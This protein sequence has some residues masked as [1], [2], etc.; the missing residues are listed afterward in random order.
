MAR[1]AQ[2]PVAVAV[3]ATKFQFYDSGIMTP[4]GC[5][6]S[7][8]AVNH[9]VTIIG[10][11]RTGSA[12]YWIVRNSWGADWGEGGYLRMQMDHNTCG[13]S[14]YPYAVNTV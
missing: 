6:S 5:S 11:D 13:I 10:Y 3:D 9:A 8:N 12:P 14:D 4:Y 7:D 2:A 1:V